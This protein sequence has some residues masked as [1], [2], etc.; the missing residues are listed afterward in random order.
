MPVKTIDVAFP[1]FL[2]YLQPFYK[3]FGLFLSIISFAGFVYLLKKNFKFAIFS[4]LYVIVTFYII[5]QYLDSPIISY[6]LPVYAILCIY[7]S[8][9]FQLVK[10]LISILFKKFIKNKKNI[11]TQ[12]HAYQIPVTIILLLLLI[13]PII[14]AS[15]NYKYSDNSKLDESYIAWNK[16]FNNI[17]NDSYLFVFSKVYD[18]GTYINL[19]EQKEKRIKFISSKD[20]DYSL[21]LITEVFNEGKTVYIIGN[22][23]SINKKL[24][25]EKT[26]LSFELKKMD[27]MLSV[28]KITSEKTNPEL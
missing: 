3:N 17:E 20:K 7:S 12:N 26:G 19:Y 22:E 23:Q 21:D 14:L 16:I 15:I 1:V 8:Y 28:K 6:L 5:I 18:V 4:F 2:A 11:K 10:D 13:Q 27:E 25:F 9:F 24:N